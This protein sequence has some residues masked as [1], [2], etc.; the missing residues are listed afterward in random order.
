MQCRSHVP[1]APE[2]LRMDSV[3]TNGHRPRSADLDLGRIEIRSRCSKVPA[4]VTVHSKCRPTTARRPLSRIV[5]LA[6]V[7]DAATCT[8]RAHIGTVRGHNLWIA[9]RR[10]VARP[11]ISDCILTQGS[12]CHALAPQ[13]RG[14]NLNRAHESNALHCGAMSTNPGA[15]ACCSTLRACVAAETQ[16]PSAEHSSPR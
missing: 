4:A 14:K 1:E 2:V 11:F 15:H 10:G 3:D 9:A 7:F 8:H 13:S 16:Q 6:A 12:R 5:T